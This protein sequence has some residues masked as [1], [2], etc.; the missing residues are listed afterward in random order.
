[1]ANTSIDPVIKIIKLGYKVKYVF[2]EVIKGYNACYNVIYKGKH[3]KSPTADKL[4]IPLN[5]I[6][7]NEK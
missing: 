6:W 3:I 7:I 1:M 5:R 2:N 4:G